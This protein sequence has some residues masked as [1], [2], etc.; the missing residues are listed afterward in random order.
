MWISGHLA[1]RG[2]TKLVA[3]QTE[4]VKLE[5]NLVSKDV[6]AA[7]QQHVTSRPKV[8]QLKEAADPDMT[9][10]SL[11]GSIPS[12]PECNFITAKYFRERGAW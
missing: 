1:L 5:D 6:M 9:E 8:S 12:F 3:L 11:H 7:H 10:S 2:V 4:I